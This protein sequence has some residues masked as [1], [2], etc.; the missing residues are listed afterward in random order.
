MPYEVFTT[1]ESITLRLFGE[2]TIAEA[3]AL[4][5]E[6]QGKLQGSRDLVVE[7]TEVKRMDAAMGQLLLAAARAAKRVRLVAPSVAWTKTLDRLGIV[8]EKT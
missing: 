8:L 4:H 1:A 5:A 2:L 6:I 7:A 3:S